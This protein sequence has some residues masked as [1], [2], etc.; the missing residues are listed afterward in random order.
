MTLAPVTDPVEVVDVEMMLD[1]FTVTSDTARDKPTGEYP[2]RVTAEY[3][4]REWLS[5]LGPAALLFARKCDYQLAQL[6]TEQTS[7]AVLVHRWADELGIYPEE[8]LAAKNRLLRFRMAKWEPKSNLFVIKRHWPPVPD[9][10]ATPEHKAALL[11][12]P[13]SMKT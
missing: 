6:K 10:I 1:R 8:L 2:H 12:L 13:D 9:S 4:E 7:I 5:Y 3:V 11:S